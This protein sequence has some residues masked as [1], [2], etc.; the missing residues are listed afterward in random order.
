MKFKSKINKIIELSSKRS[1]HIIEYHPDI[2]IHFS[3][4]SEVLKY[5]DQ[6]RKSRYDPE[7]L[8]F[9]KYF[10]NIEEG[11]FLV[12][13][14][15]INKRNFVLTSYLTDKIKTGEIIYEKKSKSD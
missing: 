8:L 4:I 15:K 13:V 5:P 2:K 10:A 9:Y 6:I 14:V 11:K 7:A 1:K 3:K 12:V